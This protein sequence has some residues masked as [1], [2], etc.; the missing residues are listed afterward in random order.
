MSQQRGPPFRV[1]GVF[2]RCGVERTLCVDSSFFTGRCSLRT[3]EEVLQ[4]FHVSVDKLNLSRIPA[5]LAAKQ[6]YSGGLN[7]PG[8][9]SEGNHA[10][11]QGKAQTPI[12]SCAHVSPELNDL[13]R[14]PAASRI[15]D[16]A[17]PPAGMIPSVL[18]PLV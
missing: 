12:S 7:G 6:D 14:Q 18:T 15:D 3:I 9:S 11:L 1:S 5:L 4:Y 17:R 8:R 16:A 13:F 10:R 2:A